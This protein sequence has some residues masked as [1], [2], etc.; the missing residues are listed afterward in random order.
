M[1]EIR[2]IQGNP[3]QNAKLKSTMEENNYYRNLN[4]LI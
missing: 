3:K 1:T 2:T 4:Q